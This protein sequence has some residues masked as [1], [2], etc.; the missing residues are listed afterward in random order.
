MRYY[1]TLIAQKI[2]YFRNF[3]QR[4]N[5]TNSQLLTEGSQDWDLDWLHKKSGPSLDE[6]RDS[7]VRYMILEFQTAFPWDYVVG[8]LQGH[9]Q[10]LNLG[11][12]GGALPCLPLTW[13]AH[14]GSQM[15]HS[16]SKSLNHMHR[17]RPIVSHSKWYSIGPHLH[18][19]FCYH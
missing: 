6:K 19:A 7:Y 8:V 12:W 15:L 18:W 4:G 5:D 9:G 2:C 10:T 14:G 17:I 13:G 3:F 1:H 16:K 11:R